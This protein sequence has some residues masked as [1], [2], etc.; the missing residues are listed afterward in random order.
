MGYSFRQ[1][2]NALLPPERPLAFP[3]DGGPTVE[4]LRDLRDAPHLQPFLTEVRAEAQRARETPITVLPFSRF[5]LFDTVG[6]R[7]EYERPYFERRGRL[8]ALVLASLVD[9]TDD[10]LPAL[11][12]TIWAICD[13]YTWSV[14]A[15]LGRSAG[16]ERSGRVR[17]EQTIDLFA[18]E[19]AHALAETLTLLGDQ[20]DPWIT[21]RVRAEIEHR[22]F[23]PLFYEPAHFH[24]ESVPMNWAS[25]CAGAVGMAALLL[26][27]DRERLAGMVDR[28]ARTMECFLEGYGDDGGCPEGIGYWQYGFGYYVYFAEMLHDYTAGQLDLLQGDKIQRIASFPVAI[29]L[30][31][32]AFVNYSD[33]QAHLALRSGLMSRLATR[34]GAPV[35]SLAGV[36]SFHDDHCYRWAH[37]TRDL[38]WTDPALLHHPTPDGTATFADLAW[39]VDRHTLDGAMVAFSAKGGHND[40]P[41]NHNDLGHFI[42]HVGGESLLTDLG[43][44]LY[45]RDYFGPRRYEHLHTASAGHSVPI[46]DGQEQRAGQEH[47]ARVVRNE[48]GSEAL[49]FELDLTNAYRVSSLEQFV[50]TFTWS[51]DHDK[52]CARLE[53]TDSFAFRRVPDALEELFISFHQPRIAPGTVVWQGRAGSVSLTFDADRFDATIETIP[54]REHLEEPVMVYRLRLQATLLEVEAIYCFVFTCNLTS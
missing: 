39:V 22:T 54:T 8:A 49:V 35:P 41:H 34:V 3:G 4:R 11:E 38:L 25:V 29:S 31:G 14:P 12:D 18:A 19:T 48:T 20:L 30:G 21:Y 36:P 7:R 1:I 50:R 40:E 42:L 16:P 27:D 51:C 24:W 44:G 43:A 15:H 53:L 2:R 37:L 47:A 26:E 45:T 13:E 9:T 52:A 6:T 32:D 46:I 5:H 28:V 10:W 23:H 33:G 17:P